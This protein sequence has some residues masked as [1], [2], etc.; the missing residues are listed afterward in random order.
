[1]LLLYLFVVLA[2]DAHAQN[3]V[4][5]YRNN[6]ARSGENLQETILTPANVNPGQFGKLFS[7]PV[8]GQVYA[9]PLYMHSV[10]IQG[11]GIHN[12]VFAATTHA[13]VYAFDA[14][15]NT[16]LNAAPLWHVSFAEAAGET[17]I[18]VADVLGCRSIAPE[19]GIIG[20]PVIDPVT[21]TLYVVAMT[22]RNVTVFQRLHALDITTGAER[23]GSPVTIEADVPGTG[24]GFS[25]THVKFSP[26]LHKNRAGLLLLND[27]VYSAWASHCDAGAY[28]GWI[29]GHDTRNLRRVAAFNATPNGYR[30]SFWMGGAAPAADAEGN[31]YL[32]SGNGEFN[33]Q[34]NGSEFGNSFLKLS[35][36]RGLKVADYFTPFNQLYLDRQDIDLGSSGVLLLPDAAGST[37]HPNLLISAGK[38]GRIYLLDRDAMGRFHV[39]SDSQ[40]VQSIDRAIGAV[41]GGPAYFNNTVYFSAAKDTL[42]AFSISQAR[43][44]TEPSSHSSQVFADQGSVPAVSANGSLNGIV[45]IVESS[46]GGTLHAYDASNLTNELYNSRMRGARDSLGPFVKFSVPT[47]ANGK[48]YVGTGDTLE[49]FGLLDQPPVP[50]KPL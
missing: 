11:K 34:A 38:E 31:I 1:M 43:L 3:N 27:V 2:L 21:N 24:D 18:G 45:W 26:Y 13:G 20:T 49:V 10:N 6:M 36:W 39:G 32:I 9:Q 33:A 23:P 17:T 37:S 15:S 22:K 42:K 14:D 40:I 28:H 30:G 19:L 44:E 5:T 4:T 16:G 41:F 48:V 47:I 7:R 46:F 50:S 12:V 29:I 8:D 25:S 35:T